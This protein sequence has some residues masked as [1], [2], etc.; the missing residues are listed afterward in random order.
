MEARYKFQD[1]NLKCNFWENKSYQLF[2]DLECDLHTLAMAMQ[3][4]IGI[5]DKI[6][7]INGV[8]N[9]NEDFTSIISILRSST[10]NLLGFRCES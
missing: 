5:L 3:T 2:K 6:S 4:F 7:I 1:L 10:Q 9:R 8:V